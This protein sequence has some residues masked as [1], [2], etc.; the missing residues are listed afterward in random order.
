[1]SLYLITTKYYSVILYIIV[2][3]KR[4]SIIL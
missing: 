3:D 2:L 4:T 1:M